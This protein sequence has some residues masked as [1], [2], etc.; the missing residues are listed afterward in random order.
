V[1]IGEFRAVPETRKILHAAVAEVAAVGNASGA[2]LDADVVAKTITF[3]DAGAP[4]MKP[5]MQRDVESG[6]LSELESMVGIVVRLGELHSVPTPVMG[7]AYAF[8]KPR[9]IIAQQTNK[10]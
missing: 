6:K 4:G 3:I 9:E 7:M 2:A 1:T 5:S 10:V 8:L